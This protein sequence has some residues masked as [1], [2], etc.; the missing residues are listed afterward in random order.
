MDK[1]SDGEFSEQILADLIAQ[2]YSG[3]ELLT[4]FKEIRRKIHPGCISNA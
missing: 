2:G 4:K 3:K 1:V